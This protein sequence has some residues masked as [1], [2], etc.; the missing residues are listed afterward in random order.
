MDGTLLESVLRNFAK[1]TGNHLCQ[2]IF[3]NKAVGLG[4]Q[5][6]LKRD[7]VNFS[8]ISNNTFLKEHIRIT[9]SGFCHTKRLLLYIYFLNQKA[10]IIFEFRVCRNLF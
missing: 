6:Y 9:A 5:L 10:E 4:L 3:F 1:F 2:N 7:A 8:E